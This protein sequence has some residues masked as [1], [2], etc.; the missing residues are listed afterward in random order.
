MNEGIDHFANLNSIDMD[1]LFTA[2]VF[3]HTSFTLSIISSIP[4]LLPLCACMMS[5]HASIMSF[6]NEMKGN[7]CK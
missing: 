5:F 3:Q 2:S 6:Q 7:G 1:Q 4:Q